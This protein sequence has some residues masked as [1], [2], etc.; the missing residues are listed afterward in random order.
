MAKPFVKWA[1]GKSQ[2]INIIDECFDRYNGRYT[3]YDIEENAHTLS[4]LKKAYSKI[5]DG[6]IFENEGLLNV[7]ND[8]NY[9]KMDVKMEGVKAISDFKLLVNDDLMVELVNKSKSYN[10]NIRKNLWTRQA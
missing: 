3:P 5:K 1:G 10:G 8:D 9:E 7:K 4:F 6:S 2:L